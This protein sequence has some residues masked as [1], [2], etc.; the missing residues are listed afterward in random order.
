MAK[1]ATL[2]IPETIGKLLDNLN[3]PYHP[4]AAYPIDGLRADTRIQVRL[5]RNVAPKANVDRYAAAMAAGAIYPP[6]IVTKDRVRVDGSTRIEAALRLKRHDFPAVVIDVDADSADAAVIQKLQAVGLAMNQTNGQPLDRAELRDGVAALLGAGWTTEVIGRYLGVKPNTIGGIRLELAA[7]ARREGLGI[8]GN[9][10]AA[11]ALRALGRVVKLNDEPWKLLHDLARDAGLTTG[12]INRLGKA[13]QNAGSDAAAVALLTTERSERAEQ[14]SQHA[15]TGKGK[16]PI[17]DAVRRA[18]GVVLARQ[19]TEMV[20]H[21]QGQMEA[22][23]E[24]LDGAIARLNATV[25][26]QKALV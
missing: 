18:L 26:A 24:T 9:G 2:G 12:D 19:P 11:P 5:E 8:S 14:I 15:L 20:E 10:V 17:A 7:Q 16:A 25:Q 23:I 1:S 6:V 4:E 3:L 13:V 22:Y 21:R